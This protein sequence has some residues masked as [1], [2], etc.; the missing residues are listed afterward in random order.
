VATRSGS[1][2]LGVAVTVALGAACTN[3]G[4][5]ITP[6][7]V[8]VQKGPS[9]SGDGQ[10]GVVAAALPLPLRVTVTLVGQPHRGDVV[11]WATSGT[12]A[13]VSPTQSITDA[14]GLATTSWTVS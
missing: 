9:P 2:A 13:S 1:S 11:T 6:P 8:V 10:V 3:T 14:N 12:G 7:P 5:P 4:G